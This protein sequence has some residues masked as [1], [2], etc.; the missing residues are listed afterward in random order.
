VSRCPL[1]VEC[2]TSVSL[3]S[4]NKGQRGAVVYRWNAALNRWTECRAVLLT[5]CGGRSH[6]FHA[7]LPSQVAIFV[8]AEPTDKQ[9]QIPLIK[10]NFQG[11][12]CKFHSSRQAGFPKRVP[13]SAVLWGSSQYNAIRR[14][15]LAGGRGVSKK[16]RS[17]SREASGPCRS[18]CE[19]SGHPPDQAC[20][21]P[22]MAQCSTW[23]TPFASMIT[24][25]V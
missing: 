9:H 5:L 3:E 18:V 21:S 16:N 14:N 7:A 23:G 10:S 24:V 4:T 8:R 20:P 25:R 12:E 6:D 11:R 15:Q 13:D 19:P 17:I 2:Q 1:L 22:S